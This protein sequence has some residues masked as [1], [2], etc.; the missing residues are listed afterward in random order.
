MFENV[1]RSL[2]YDSTIFLAHK[3]IYVDTNTDHFTPL[4][5]HMR[6]NQGKAVVWK[7][8]VREKVK[9]LIIKEWCKLIFFNSAQG[10]YF[11]GI[12]Y[13]TWKNSILHSSI[14]WT[15]KLLINMCLKVAELGNEAL[16]YLS[17]SFHLP[18]K[19]TVAV[20]S[21]RKRC[22]Q[23]LSSKIMLCPPEEVDRSYEM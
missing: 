9:R 20:I 14:S 2:K 1:S 11:G 22:K 8:A 5:L 4:V 23:G 19:S 13:F 7:A 6:G 10:G 18:Q 17:L 16:E 15:N 21:R 3:H 12:T